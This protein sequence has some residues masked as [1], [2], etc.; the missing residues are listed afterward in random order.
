[1]SRRVLAGLTAA[2]LAAAGTA[3][4]E[5]IRVGMLLTLS[6]PPAALGQQARDG[7]LLAMEDL[8]GELGGIE[9][10]V[11]VED[12]ELRP[13]VAQTKARALIERDDVDVV[14][15][16]IF[17]N[18]LQAIFKPVI[19]SDRVLLSP[20]AGPST[21]AGRNC[22]P[23]F[24]AVSYQNDQNHEVLGRY[25][26]D[27]G[28]AS[29]FL[30]APNYQAGR[31]SL[32]GFKRHYTGTIAD[33]VYVPLGHQ[34]FSAEIARI[35][36][37]DPEALFTFMPGGMG[38]RL[39]KQFRQAGLADDV[40]FLSAFTVDETTLPAQGADARGFFGGGVWAPDVDNDASS[41]FVAAFDE[42]YGYIPGVYAMFGY[43]TAM[44]LDAA[45]AAVEGDLSDTD[46]F[47]AAIKDAEFSSLR[48]DFRFNN[49]HFP[50]QDFYLLEVAE[51]E[52]GRFQTTIAER[53]FDDYAD[54]YHE[55]CGME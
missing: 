16:T 8:G 19:E 40:T 50:V 10:E 6:G 35:A 32:A 25:A 44:L 49:N 29:V 45:V 53:V 27:E 12:I 9:T 39:V 23:H 2:L 55:D 22:H 31:D 15:G 36:A 7:F 21:F 30:L 34:D 3:A 13:D 26:E 41:A 28:M 5:P 38:V 18:M 46:V 51:R 37:A 1:M 48:G 52:D 24:F 11:L 4:A 14:V 43:D 54:A 20:N 17:S 33:E 42:R 47:A